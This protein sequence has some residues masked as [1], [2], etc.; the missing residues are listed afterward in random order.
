MATV[1]TK[2][3]ASSSETKEGTLFYQVIH[4]RVARQIHTGY[5]LYPHE[6]DTWHSMVAIPPDIDGNRRTYL[7]ALKSKVAENV[8][9]LKDIIA[10]LDC[11]GKHYTADDVVTHYQ[12]LS[13]N[14]GFI[15]FTNSLI[16]ELKRMGRSCTAERYTTVRNSF[17]RFIAERN[18]ILL[19]Q[20]DSGLMAEYE[21][22]L[23]ADGVCPNSSSFYMRGLRAIYNRAVDKELTVQRNPF[24]HV[25][26][27]I[28]KTVKRA[29]PLETIRLIRDL[30]LTLEP[31]LDLARDLFMFSFYTR[32]MS[33][34]DMAF[35]KKSNLKNG[36]LSYRRQKTGQLLFIKWEKPM[37][38]IVN[39]YDTTETPYLL[40]VIKDMERDGRRQYKSAVHRIN[41]LLKRLGKQVG[42]EIPL[43][44]YVARHGWA[45]IARSKN[46]PISIISEAMGHDSEKTT[47]I[48]LASLDTSAVDKANSIILKSL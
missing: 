26:T 25:Y 5:R 8:T 24:K 37:Q 9:I 32:G 21:S 23:K 42:L 48:Y 47:L 41:H 28:D 43:T 44:T 12:A 46:I 38:E 4:N 11:V 1:K 16:E 15:R 7:I 36:I 39:K 30:D 22:H 6:W 14:G 34:I 2:F 45:S 19:N 33:F 18:D 35:L 29:I 3:R 27:G 20:M 10:K 31:A 17:M 40:P 13:E